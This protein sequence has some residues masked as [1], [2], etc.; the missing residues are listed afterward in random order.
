VGR[1]GRRHEEDERFYPADSRYI[2]FTMPTKDNS[3][4][5]CSEEH[6]D[7]KFGTGGC[8]VPFSLKHHSEMRETLLDHK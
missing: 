3:D 5:V 6:I 4:R 2:E 8:L 7:S 1:Y